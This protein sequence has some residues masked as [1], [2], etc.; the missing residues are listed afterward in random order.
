VQDPAAVA[1]LAD[2]AQTRL[3]RRS[4][5]LDD[6]VDRLA[7]LIR[8]IRAWARGEYRDVSTQAIV[9][10]VAAVLYF[11]VPLDLVPDFLLHVG[12]VDDIAVISWVFDQVRGELDAFRRWEA[13]EAVARAAPKAPADDAGRRGD[14]GAERADRDG[15]TGAVTDD[16]TE[17]KEAAGRDPDRRRTIGSEPGGNG[18]NGREDA[19]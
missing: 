18:E 1:R 5:A 16:R 2:R 9:A 12:L 14:A 4:R 7:T 8:L 11:V 15:A 19:R 3:R 10:V 13:D 17:A 6:V